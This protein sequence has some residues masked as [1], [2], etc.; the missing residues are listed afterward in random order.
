[1]KKKNSSSSSNESRTTKKLVCQTESLRKGINGISVRD[2]ERR[3]TK[4]FWHLALAKRSA[5]TRAYVSLCADFILDSFGA[6]HTY[7]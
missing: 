5:R 3:F 7:I 1:M 2:L 6:Y 4:Q